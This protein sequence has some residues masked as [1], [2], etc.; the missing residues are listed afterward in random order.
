[1]NIIQAEQKDIKTVKEITQ[2]TIKYVYPK[3][4]PK[5]AVDLFINYHSDERIISDIS[6]GYVYL[7]EDDG[8]ITGTVTVEENHI[9]RLFVLPAYQHKGYGRAL[10]DFSEDLIF[11]SFM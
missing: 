1:M 7:L 2:T 11:R 10:L 3:Y 9:G 4:Y 8:K 6:N 5:G